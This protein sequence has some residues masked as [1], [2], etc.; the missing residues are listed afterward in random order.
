MHDQEDRPRW[1]W[2]L[3]GAIA[4][5]LAVAL[6]TAVLFLPYGLGH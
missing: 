5:I 2:F 6:P 3:L 4:A 1:T